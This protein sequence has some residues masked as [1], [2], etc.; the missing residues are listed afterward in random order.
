MGI[1]GG[2]R[3]IVE[4]VLEASLTTAVVES[5][6]EIGNLPKGKIRREPYINSK[7]GTNFTYETYILEINNVEKDVFVP[8][9]NWEHEDY[10]WF[11]IDKLSELDVHPGV[12]YVLKQLDTF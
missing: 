12:L 4:D 10:G 9:L 6:E 7:L 2:A 3:N 11:E 5:Q 8:E 1:T